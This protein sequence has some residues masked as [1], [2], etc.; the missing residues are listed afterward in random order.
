[1]TVDV[2]LETHATSV[3]NERGIATGWGDEG[4]S[5]LGRMQAA[6]MGERW[7]GHDLAGVFTSDLRRAVETAQIAFGDSGIAF[8]TEP[9]LRECDYGVLTGHPVDEI[10]AVRASRVD[11]A[12]P[13]GE[14][15]RDVVARVGEM[16]RDVGADFADGRLL[17]VGHRATYYALEHL[18]G[19]KELEQVVG[20][21]FRWQPG[22]SYKLL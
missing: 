5:D 21:P 18:L 1:M 20:E 8:R 16:L 15:Y 14:S 6:E 4:L 12:F 22:W 10:E 11:E 7:R 19:G 9:R 13:G 2:T 3:D 17:L